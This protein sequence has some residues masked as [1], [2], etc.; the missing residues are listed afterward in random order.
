MSAPGSEAEQ[1]STAAPEGVPKHQMTER[2]HLR[3][4]YVRGKPGPGFLSHR[5]VVCGCESQRSA[6]SV[7]PR[8][9]TTLV[10]GVSLFVFKIKSFIG[11]ELNK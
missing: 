4:D 5:C 11:V 8:L 10:L 3:S 1:G 2:L 9:P 7:L 6:S